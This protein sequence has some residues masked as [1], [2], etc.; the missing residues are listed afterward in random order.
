M[1]SSPSF[2]Q[3]YTSSLLSNDGKSS[4]P[5]SRSLIRQPVSRMRL[6]ADFMV[7][8]SC[9]CST[10]RVA[11]FSYGTITPPIIM[12]RVDTAERSTSRPASFLRQSMASMRNGSS[13]LRA[14][15]ASVKVNRRCS[16]SGSGD[17]SWSRSSS[18][19]AMLIPI[20]WAILLEPMLAQTQHAV[21]SNSREMTRSFI[22]RD[23]INDV[24][25]DQV[26]QRP[27]EMLRR[28]AEHRGANTHAGVQG[29]DFAVRHFF[30]EPVDEMNL[31]ADSPLRTSR[32]GGD[33]LDD[34]FGRAGLVG[35]LCDLEA[36]LGM[37]ND[38]NAGM[39]APNAFDV[40]R[41]EALVDGTVSFPE[42]D[43]GA[44]YCFRGVTAEFLVG[45]PNDH[46][47][48]GDA[49]TKSG[50]PA[51]VLVGQEE[52]LFAAFERPAH[53]R[54][55]VRTGADRAAVLS[56]E[57]FD[58]GGRVH[59]GDRDHLQLAQRGKLAP[60]GL[61]LPDIGHVGHRAAGIEV[62]QD[63]R[64]M[65]AAKNVRAFGHEM[66]AAENDVAALGLGS[67]I[68]KPQRITAEIREF[69][70]FVPLV[71]M[72]ENDH[73]FAELGLG[74]SDAGVERGVGNEQVGVKIAAH[75]GF[76]LRRTE[77]VGLYGARQRRRVRDRDKGAHCRGCRLG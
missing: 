2:Q 20:R 12:I 62:R 69:Y 15:S 55:G 4:S 50:V 56:G 29:H 76:D 54:G 27:E 5:A 68:R 44:V 74:G 75:T 17:S 14:R 13:S 22:D 16:G 41:R 70:D 19:S 40:L 47:L 8:A 38:A 36:A 67:L 11:S 3:R 32:R 64:L 71:V 31:G 35:G 24:S 26:F 23:A 37:D 66:Y 7:S 28:D 51:E 21:E 73:V 18:W 72:P 46:L 63:D 77:R 39:L 1:R 6:S 61:H 65:L 30:A 52:Y 25:G 58:R 9:W 45:V 10:R 59:V 42:D 60:T 33:R 53:H 49:H 48:E 57:R 43:A 34:A